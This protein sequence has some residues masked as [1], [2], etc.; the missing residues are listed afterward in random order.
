MQSTEMFTWLGKKKLDD[1][2]MKDKIQSNQI[3]TANDD[4]AVELEESVNE[5][6]L[7]YDFIYN[8]QAELI[9]TYREISNYNEVDFA[10][11]DIVNEAVTF[12][13]DDDEPVAI[14]LSKIEDDILSEKIRDII[15]E[16]WDKLSNMLDLTSTI[17][18]RF[19]NF[20]IDG[21]LGYQKVIDKNNVVKNGILDVVELDPRYLTKYRNIDYDKETNT[22]K[23]IIEYFIYNENIK[24]D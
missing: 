20:Y 8:S 2:D 6:V 17:H 1:E 22:I 18:R 4:G 21:R 23:D 15:Y 10:I 11:E 9:D 16:K 5:F 14:D 13:D 7:N 19:K 12:G 24:E 3:A